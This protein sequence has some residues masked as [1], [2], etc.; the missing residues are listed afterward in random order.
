MNLYEIKDVR[1]GQ[2]L[3]PAVSMSFQEVADRLHCSKQLVSNSYHGNYTIGGKYKV[4][5]VDETISISDP[6]WI[7]WELRRNWF[8]KLCGK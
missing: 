4:E 3:D 7:D 6:I 8:L 2:L 5:H 1:T